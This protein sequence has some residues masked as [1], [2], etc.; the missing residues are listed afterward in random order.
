GGW[1]FIVI[2]V[3]ILITFLII[4]LGKY[5][6]MRLGSADSRPEYSFFSWMG[7]LFGA[8]LG[9][10]LVF[11]GVTEPMSHFMV[12][13][14]AESGTPQAAADAMRI[15]FFHWSF[16]PWAMYGMIGLCIGYFTHKKG[17]PNLISSTF[18]PM[19]GENNTHGKIGRLIDA[20]SLIA[21]ISGVSMSLG[22]AAT[23]LSSGLNLQFGFENSFLFVS[24]VTIIIGFIATLS[25]ISGVA[26][27]IR[28]ISDSN[29]YI[30]LF[31]LVFTLI[32]GSTPYLISSF[33]ENYGEMIGNLPWMILYSDSYGIAQSNTDSNWIG[34]WTIMYWAWWA[35]FG[36][37]VGGFLANISKGRTIREFVL[38]CTFVPGTLCC[39]WF[40]FFGGQAIHMELVE[41]LN[42]GATIMENTDNSLF[43]FL[44]Q[45]PI[46]IV[47]IPL[48][49]VLIVTLIVT[50]VNSATFIASTFSN[51]GDDSPSL[52]IRTFWGIF[53]VAN[54]I[55]FMAIG[56]LNSL[57]QVAIVMA[58][59]FI[60]IVALMVF[61]LVKDMKK[62][63]EMERRTQ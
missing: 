41:G 23:Q 59:P 26:K 7:M 40:T 57:K 58:F 5:G 27:G 48:A 46:P 25:C 32:F 8:G 50:S 63:Y 20:F 54:A 42:I 30:V 60:I 31:F 47:T 22:F 37:F 45:L 14:F 18:A 4:G 29:M 44:K 3:F 39:L 56:G 2:S 34:G 19:L 16:I 10:G 53:I 12:A 49:M 6:K 43:V 21:V 36:P 38:A 55:A 24:I 11:Y 52:G 15:T 62:V 28:Y 13:P 33:F 17:L 1:V 51:G 35:A 9:V 61:N